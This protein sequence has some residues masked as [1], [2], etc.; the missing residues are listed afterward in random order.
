MKTDVRR[1][2]KYIKMSTIPELRLGSGDYVNTSLYCQ[3]RIKGTMT[4]RG[5]FVDLTPKDTLW[6]RIRSAPDQFWLLCT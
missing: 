3:I 1:S 2:S 5:P 4:D 6:I